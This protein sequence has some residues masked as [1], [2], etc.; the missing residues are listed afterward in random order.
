MDWN[1][2]LIIVVAASALCAGYV[3]YRLRVYKHPEYFHIYFIADP[4]S[5]V[6]MIVELEQYAHSQ[7]DVQIFQFIGLYKISPNQSRAL[8]RVPIHSWSELQTELR[9]LQETYLFEVFNLT[10]ESDQ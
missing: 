8:Y 4:Q 7:K 9:R 2:I 10:T 1:V 5:V 6:Q 3:M